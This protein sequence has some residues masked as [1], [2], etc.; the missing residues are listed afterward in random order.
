MTPRALAVRALMHQEKDGYANLVL[1]G[2]LKRCQPPLDSRD[3]A[4]AARI[5]YTTVERQR[6]LDF[7]LSQYIRKPLAKLDAPVRAI[8]R[9]G[10]A[11][12]GIWMCRYP[13]QS[14]SRSS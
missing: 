2:E 14:M 12:A 5:F 8:L 9:S 10:L 3:A 4:F 13:P 11:R 7:C 6:L 1:D